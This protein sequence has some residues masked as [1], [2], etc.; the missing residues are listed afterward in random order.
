MTGTSKQGWSES[1]VRYGCDWLRRH[2]KSRR[3]ECISSRYSRISNGKSRTQSTCLRIPVLPTPYQEPQ[4]E[5]GRKRKLGGSHGNFWSLKWECIWNI[6][7]L[8]FMRV[9]S[10]GM[11]TFVKE[12]KGPLEQEHLTELLKSEG[13]PQLP[14]SS[15]C[16]VPMCVICLTRPTYLGSRDFDNR[17]EPGRNLYSFVFHDRIMSLVMNDKFESGGVAT[18]RPIILFGLS[19]QDEWQAVRGVGVFDVAYVSVRPRVECVADSVLKCYTSLRFAVA[20]R[21]V[22]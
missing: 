10:S 8:C 20:L 14:S 15:H 22:L 12:I 7:M 11:R 2:Q 19:V 17:V 21:S 9:S 4:S 1:H 3:I 13:A 16:A 5:R 18:E 6:A